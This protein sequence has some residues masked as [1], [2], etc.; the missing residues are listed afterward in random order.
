MT[1]RTIGLLFV[2]V[3][4]FAGC[5]PQMQP[6]AA[7]MQEPCSQ[8]LY[9]TRWRLVMIDNEVVKLPRSVFIRFRKDGT[10]GGFG[11]CNSFFGDA[12]VTETAIDFVRLGSTRR[13]C[14]GIEGEV[15]RRLFSMLKGT[16]WWQFDETED[17]VIFDDEHRL[18][19]EKSGE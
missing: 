11:G 8:K 12:A 10:F 14:S 1:L 9:D 2:G 16:R 17:L 7:S 6:S 5:A 13:F 18:V 3:L 15:E 19:F 4:M